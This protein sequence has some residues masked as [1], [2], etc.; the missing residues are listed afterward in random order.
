M[1]NAK[2]SFS[3]LA[4]VLVTT[5]ICLTFAWFAGANQNSFAGHSVLFI[6][7]LISIAVNWLAFLPCAIAQ[8]EKFYDLIGSITYLALM[9]AACWIAAPLDAKAIVAALMVTVWALRLGSFLFARIGRDGKDSRFDKIKI[10]PARFLV[11]WTMQASWAI[12]TAA[13]AVTIIGA[14]DRGPLDL[15]FWIGTA[16]WLIGFVI[17]I[18]ADRQKNAFK[19]DPGN[20][21]KFIDTGLWAWSQHPNYFGEI[22]LWT[23]ITII[24]LPLL[25]GWGYLVLFSPVFVIF[26]L[27][28]VSGIP[29]LDA[30]AKQRWGDNPAYRA[31]RAKTSKLVLLPPK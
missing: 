27:T 26:L 28:K 29:M 15:Y 22:M 16:I 13:A 4:T 1:S 9:G 21:G 25:S 2:R 12:F 6:C 3:S 31:Y 24:V 10:N 5:I 18:A 17:E 11:A 30:K 8:T 20:A 14:V 23:G 19:N 7:A